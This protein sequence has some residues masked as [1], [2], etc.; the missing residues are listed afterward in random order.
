MQGRLLAQA[1]CGCLERPKLEGRRKLK[2]IIILIIRGA[3]PSCSA[4][5]M[6][7]EQRKNERITDCAVSTD[8]AES[9]GVHLRSPT[10]ENSMFSFIG[11]VSK[12]KY[13]MNGYTGKDNFSLK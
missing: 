10:H 3:L 7:N 4:L 1:L 12:N 2:I 9:E 13:A 11:Q 6:A 8:C 5:E